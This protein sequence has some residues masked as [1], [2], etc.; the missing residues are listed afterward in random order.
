MTLSDLQLSF[1]GRDIVQ[2]QITRKWYNIELFSAEFGKK[3]VQLLGSTQSEM[4]YQ[5][6]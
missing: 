2:R 5:S 4:D 3:I 1:Q 6:S